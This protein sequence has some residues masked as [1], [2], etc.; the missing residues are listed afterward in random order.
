MLGVM[1][2]GVTLFRLLHRLRKLKL[3]RQ[4]FCFFP[5]LPVGLR[6][7]IWKLALPGPRLDHVRA[8]SNGLDGQRECNV[9][10]LNMCQCGN[11]KATH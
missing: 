5:K 2:G 10:P 3:G 4:T 8:V 7:R 1:C 9:V 11:G 6:L